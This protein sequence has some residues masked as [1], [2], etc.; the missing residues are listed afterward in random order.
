MC[1]C[2]F[3]CV[4]VYL[5]WVPVS[6]YGSMYH[7]ILPTITL[8]LYPM[9]RIARLTRSSML[10]VLGQDYIITANAKGLSNYSVIIVHALKN[11]S[12]P[13]VTIIGLMFG[14]LLGGAVITE[15]IFTWPG[16]GLLTIQAIK[17]RDYTLVQASVL[18]V[19]VSFVFINL[20]VDI[21]YTILDP[22]IKYT[23]S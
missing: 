22:R 13:V 6:G 10:E 16:V 20:L 11:A 4:S 21:L 12:L 1:L 19:S 8:G 17:N 2:V 15:T 3:G 7:L 9:A 18:L 23:N 5:R 14:T